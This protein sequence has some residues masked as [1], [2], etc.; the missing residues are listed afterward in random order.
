[1][2]FPCLIAFFILYYNSIFGVSPDELS[3]KSDN[4]FWIT[5]I[6]NHGINKVCLNVCL[7]FG[8]CVLFQWENWAINLPA[9]RGLRDYLHTNKMVSLV[10]PH[11]WNHMNYII[12]VFNSK[13]LNY[14]SLNIFLVVFYRNKHA[15]IVAVDKQQVIPITDSLC[16]LHTF[17]FK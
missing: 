5:R 17:K 11:Q 14:I 8:V 4:S 10:A 12:S 9:H 13:L 3:L 7:M 15:V 6:N 1:M 2:D 16:Y